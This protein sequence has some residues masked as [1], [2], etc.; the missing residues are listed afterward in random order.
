[1]SQSTGLNLSLDSWTQAAETGTI[2][3][4]YQD[5]YINAVNEALGT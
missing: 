4:E 5:D 3:T 2:A 1:M